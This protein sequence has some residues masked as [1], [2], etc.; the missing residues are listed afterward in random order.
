MNAAP[1]FFVTGLP[2]S[3]SAW[4]ANWLTTDQTLCLHDVPFDAALLSAARRVGFAGPELVE[5]FGA[6]R[7]AVPQAPWLVVWRAP[8]DSMDSFAR[9]A[10]KRLPEDRT[11]LRQLWDRRVDALLDIGRSA[12]AMDVAYAM[13]DAPKTARAIWDHLL[14]GVP[15]D[16]ARWQQLKKLNVQQ[17]LNGV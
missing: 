2:R 3:R 1:T 11:A 7:Q 14:P 12:G 13:L 17:N 9:W 8:I 15:W 10:G 6:I 5:Q 4:L 16:G